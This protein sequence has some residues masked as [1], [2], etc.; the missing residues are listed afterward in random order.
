MLGYVRL[1]KAGPYDPQLVPT[2]LRPFVPL[3]RVGFIICYW[4][5]TML[6]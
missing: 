3:I 4:Y 5:S 1:G 6:G 2:I